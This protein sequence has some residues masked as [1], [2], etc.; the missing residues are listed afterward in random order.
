MD[1]QREKKGGHQE[2]RDV[3]LSVFCCVFVEC[4]TAGRVPAGTSA[5]ADVGCF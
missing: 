1:D 3:E 2:K 4:F 5:K